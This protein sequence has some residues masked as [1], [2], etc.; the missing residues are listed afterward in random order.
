MASFV[1]TDIAIGADWRAE[2]I[3]RFEAADA[4]LDEVFE[5]Q[6]DGKIRTLEEAKEYARKI[7]KKL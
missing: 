1:S 3:K 6:L 2:S 5:K 7:I 4:E